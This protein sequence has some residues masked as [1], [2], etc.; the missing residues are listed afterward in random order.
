VPAGRPQSTSPRPERRPTESEERPDSE[1]NQTD[2]GSNTPNAQCFK[3]TRCVPFNEA[4]DAYASPHELQL[5][6]TACLEEAEALR[7]RSGSRHACFRPLD[8]MGIVFFNRAS[9][10]GAF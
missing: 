7:I 10:A 3:N 5:R 6:G 1:M 8:S 9:L 4:T 2:S